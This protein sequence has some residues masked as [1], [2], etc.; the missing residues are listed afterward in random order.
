MIC[1]GTLRACLAATTI[2]LFGT[3]GAMAD[4]GFSLADIPEIKNK[5]PIHVALE[6]GGAAD[7]IIPYLQKFAE[8]TGVPVTSESMVFA[9]IYS[10]EVVEL[11]GRTGAYDVVVTETSWTNEWRDYLF[12]IYELAESYDPD[13]RDGIRKVLDGIDPGLLRMASTRDGTLMGMPYYTYTMVSIYRDDLFND[14]G[15]K[16][17]FKDKYGY[18]LA[19]AET[20]EQLRDQGE[21]FTRAK[22]EMLRGEPLEDNFYG[23]SLMAGRF[24]HVQ[25]EL[26]AMIW[27]KGANWASPVR[28]DDGKLIGFTIDDGDREALKWA[29]ETYQDY[30][31]FA[32]PGSENAFWDFATAQFVGG[33]TAIIPL[34][35]N[36]LWN[37]AST[38]KDEVPGAMAAAAPVVGNRPYTGAFHFAPSKDSGN[39]EAAYWL[40]KYIGSH[41]TQKEMIEGG[42]AGTHAKVL[43]EPDKTVETNYSAY[44]WIPPTLAQWEKQLPD[45]NDYLHFNSSAFGKIYEQMT[46][47]GHENATKVTTPEESLKAWEESFDRLQKKFGELPVQ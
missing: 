9:T 2:A 7:L 11:Q 23:L 25:D 37:W 44:G 45:V 18:D 33:N 16:A 6:A 4:D 29:F 21:F 3:A 28:D 10:K 20:W 13:G 31:Q 38:V 26:A 34:M 15:E 19:P 27:S 14:P 30:M 42:W 43:G 46:I 32:P 39:P 5:E 47:I 36:G 22:G 40:L 12:P 24:P 35:Y 1:N 41:A 17:A 8:A